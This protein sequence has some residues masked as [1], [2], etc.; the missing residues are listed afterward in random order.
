[1]PSKSLLQGDLEHTHPKLVD[2]RWVSMSKS[3]PFDSRHAQAQ[4]AV[5]HMVLRSLVSAELK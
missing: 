5:A 1:M 2:E 4:S 3:S